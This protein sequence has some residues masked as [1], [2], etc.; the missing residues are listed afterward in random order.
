VLML[1]A[2]THVPRRQWADLAQRIHM[3][4]AT[5]G[6]F[7][8]NVPQ[9]G[10]AG[11][12]EEDFLG[13]GTTNWTNAYGASDCV[14]LVELVGFRIVEAQ[15]LADDEPDHPGWFWILAEKQGGID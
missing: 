6:L 9:E 3:W 5:G 13:F 14:D 11:W 1:Y 8:L 4:L 7:L 15:T 10:N 12:L 2:I